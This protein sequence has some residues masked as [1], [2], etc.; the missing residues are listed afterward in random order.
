MTLSLWRS[1]LV[2]GLRA[3]PYS[4]SVESQKRFSAHQRKTMVRTPTQATDAKLSI[5]PDRNR[6]SHASRA[7]G[8]INVQQANKVE[9]LTDRWTE[10]TLLR[11]L[12]IDLSRPVI[13][14]FL[15]IHALLGLLFFFVPAIDLGFSHLF[16]TSGK[17]FAFGTTSSSRVLPFLPWITIAFVSLSI[18]LL[19]RNAVGWWRG[20][21][22][23]F[24]SA[25]SR[26]VIFLLFTLGLG[27]G[28]LVNGILKDHSGR[29]RP[30]QVEAFGG[31]RQFTAAFTAT[32]P[33]K[34]NCSFVSGD[35]S[36]GY[37]LLAFLFI[38]RKR[39]W[40]IALAAY[41]M[42]TAIG[43][44]RIAQGA[45]FLSDVIFAGFFTFL[46]AWIL[47]FLILKPEKDSPISLAAGSASSS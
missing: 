3:H 29:A 10:S 35:A 5:P 8:A 43:L 30:Y 4:T 34:S 26:S 14:F 46:V 37:Y 17:G 45:H 6:V 18:L 41:T 33:C 12:H 42:G 15:G 21:Q 23:I 24:F 19:I 11:R 20:R 47:H 16:Y 25:S 2:R 22:L 27:P 7:N 38:A 40:A 13:L 28:L 36:I 44:V 1:Q 32:G 31:D 39:R 9:R